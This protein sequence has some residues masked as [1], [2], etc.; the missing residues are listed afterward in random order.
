METAQN[1]TCSFAFKNIGKAI[2]VTVYTSFAGI[3]RVGSFKEFRQVKNAI[4][5]RVCHT[6]IGNIPKDPTDFVEIS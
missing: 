1:Q 3:H 6:R 4:S 2:T 5:V